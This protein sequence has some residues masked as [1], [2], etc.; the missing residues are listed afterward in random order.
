M[1]DH[2][3]TLCEL[4]LTCK[5]VCMEASGEPE[6][7]G[8]VVGEAP[9]ANEDERGTPFVGRAGRVLD[10]AL[11][12]ATNMTP[13]AAR[14]RLVVTNAVKCRP[15][16]N[17]TPTAEQLDA[18]VVYLEKEIETWD[19]VAILALGNV[20]TITL[21]GTGGIAALRE[22]EHY[23]NRENVTRVFV[24]F[25]PAFVLRQGYESDAAEMFKADVSEFI[26]YIRRGSGR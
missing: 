23:L 6:W 1:Y 13:K 4:H 25:H 26:R 10:R 8:M 9:G 19:P 7:P 21:L 14:Q 17:S 22:S 20:A 15:P 16:N 11:T 2:S 5:T 18:C 12:A 24:T 3:C